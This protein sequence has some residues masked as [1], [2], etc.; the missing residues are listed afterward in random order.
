M[1][2]YRMNKGTWEIRW[3][4]KGKSY[5]KNLHIPESLIKHAEKLA[6]ERSEEIE[7]FISKLESG[8]LEVLN[9]LL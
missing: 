6:R 1:A 3:S 5:T 4:Y 2:S 7:L 8:L 9:R